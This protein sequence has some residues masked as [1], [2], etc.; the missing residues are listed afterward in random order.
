MH[1]PQT[2]DTSKDLTIDFNKDFNFN[3]IILLAP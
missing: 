1:K 2:Y 3:D